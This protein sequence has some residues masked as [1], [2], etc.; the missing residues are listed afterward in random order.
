MDKNLHTTSTLSSAYEL[1]LA[2]DAHAHE[3]APAR[4][5]KRTRTFQLGNGIHVCPHTCTTQASYMSSL[6]LKAA[7]SDW[8][9][10]QN[11]VQQLLDFHLQCLI[12]ASSP[13]GRCE[14][15]TC[16]SHGVKCQSSAYGTGL[17]IL[18]L[19][20]NLT[21]HNGHLPRAWAQKQSDE[22]GKASKPNLIPYDFSYSLLYV[23]AE[24]ETSDKQQHPD[25]A[26]WTKGSNRS[27]CT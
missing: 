1:N 18:M 5:A 26:R 20:V 16:V 19:A 17:L 2:K 11:S 10:L 7:L 8:A 23:L 25:V 15:A 14:P 27:C 21:T 13:H 24:V 6:S 22:A 4:P 3:P 12:P 9:S